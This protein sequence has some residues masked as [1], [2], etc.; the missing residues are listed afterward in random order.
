[1]GRKKKQEKTDFLYKNLIS[2]SIIFIGIIIAIAILQPDKTLFKKTLINILGK[3]TLFFG[4]L[5][6][7]V[8]VY[9]NPI[10]KNAFFSLKKVIGVFLIF[11]STVLIDIVKE[12]G[13]FLERVLSPTVLQ[14]IGVYGSW[15]LSIMLG[16]IGLY[17]LLEN[18]LFAIFKT[19]YFNKHKT[20]IKE[21]VR[22]FFQLFRRKTKKDVKETDLEELEKDLFNEEEKDLKEDTELN[23][24]QELINK[25]ENQT[26]NT[27]IE[28][29]ESVNEPIS[30]IKTLNRANKK[31]TP[32]IKPRENISSES[33]AN[34]ETDNKLKEKETPKNLPLRNTIWEYPP[35]SLLIKP[36]INNSKP[37]AGNIEERKKTIERT[38]KSF[39]INARVADYNVGPS[40]T[41]YALE[42]DKGVKTSK[43]TNL[44]NDLALA[45]ASPN[46]QVRIEAPI[47]GK[48]LI[49]IEVPNLSQEIVYLQDL[50][51][52]KIYKKYVEKSKLTIA[53]GKDVGGNK[54]YYPLNKMPH[55]LIAGATGS[56]KSVMV[57]SIITSL[58][59]ANSPDECK[60]ILVDP[61]RV[62]LLHYNNIPHLLTPVI[63]E[64][65]VAVS[66]LR[67]VV[68]EM[69]RR[70]QVLSNFG[71]RNIDSYNEKS[72]FQ[73]L[74][75][76]VV[77][78]DEL[79]DLMMTSSNEA[80]KYIVR[81]AQLSR[82]TGI[83]LVLAT[84]RPSTDII[85]GS[86]KA[87]IPA[88]IAFNVTSNIDSRV[89]IDSA[90]A[91]KLLGRGDMLF[92]SPESSKPKRIQG[93][94]VQDEEINRLVNYLK[95]SD[96][97]PEYNNEI[98]ESANN[99]NT[100]SNGLSK[101]SNKKWSDDLLPEA[102]K[103]MVAEGK[104]SASFLQRRLSIGYARAARLIDELESL[105]VVSPARGSKPREILIDDPSEILG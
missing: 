6:I 16:F 63:T 64:P 95:A 14:I 37:R 57:H 46:G 88:R 84:Q 30:I 38:L 7:F 35:L 90:G 20:T 29:I 10:I 5:L 27:P 68:E 28:I 91:E 51:M 42:V 87:N 99:K 97:E 34:Q 66:S 104:G 79:A 76:I 82:A 11:L 54:V 22:Y 25:T 39:G 9:L 55:L 53:L 50:L 83:H 49:G 67:W 31:Y 59:F 77:I 89:I 105:G 60:F 62:E 44:Q 73:A 100:I 2:I 93:V 80:E 13:S 24:Q 58:L 26:K 61:K 94:Y 45:L 18:K 17:L 47:P 21:K 4:I 36:D 8:G 3:S 65:S 75:Y 69:E 92:V 70:L 33:S 52:D 12:T 43:I 32:S 101:D 86:I 98:L 78:L 56:G 102:V 96:L 103:I 71:A 41:Q 48:S 72:G 85:T 23:N 40:V 81:I 74:P 19:L 15:A 1:M